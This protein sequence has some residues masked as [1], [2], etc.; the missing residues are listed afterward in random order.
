M[1]L[2]NLWN[3]R[4]PVLGSMQMAQR[5]EG[6]VVAQMVSIVKS[7]VELITG[8]CL[9]S[10]KLTGLRAGRE[11]WGRHQTDWDQAARHSHQ[12][13]VVHWVKAHVADKDAARRAHARDNRLSVTRPTT[14]Q[15]RRRRRASDRIRTARG[16]GK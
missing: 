1:G 3:E 16:W 5:G 6:F 10:R 4:G 13:E 12:V 15:M 7:G 9:V 14:G 2:G 11:V 8:S